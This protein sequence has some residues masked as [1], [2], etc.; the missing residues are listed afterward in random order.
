VSKI[1]VDFVRGK[2]VESTHQVKALVTTVDGKVLL[3]TN[4]DNEYFFPRSSIKIFQAIPFVMSNAIKNYKLN[5]KHI[6]LACASHKG[7]KFHIKELK[8][9]ISKINLKTKNLQCGIHA[10]LDKR[11]SEKIIYSRKKFNELHNNCAGKHLGMLTS[12]LVNNQSITNYLDYN[13]VHQKNIRKIF[14]KFTES[15]LSKKN[16]SLDGC[17]APQYSF[18]IKSISKALNNLIKSYKNNYDY[19][20]QVR[21]LVNSIL[22]NPEFIG[23]TVSFDTKVI[24][25]SKGR[26][27][28]KSG[29]EGVFLFVDFQNEISGVIKITDGNERAIPIAILNIFKKFKVMSKVELKNLEKKEKFELKNHAGR[30]IG[31]ISL[32]MK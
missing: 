1:H 17:S 25:A 24:K 26:I 10:P 23:G 30:N 18:K 2:K 15:K 22:E 29:A 11:A 7:E 6:A 28:C 19:S 9:W 8:K 32:T 20:D 3:S 13:H 21:T 31:F 14:N 16:F 27:F 5:N 12:C 4:N